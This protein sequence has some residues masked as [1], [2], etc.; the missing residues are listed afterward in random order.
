MN[1]FSVANTKIICSF[2]NNPL[3]SLFLP[4]NGLIKCSWKKMWPKRPRELH[5]LIKQVHQMSQ[6][7]Q[8][9]GIK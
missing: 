7:V 4:H 5:G 6:C 8:P 2:R 9:T 3:F 1:S